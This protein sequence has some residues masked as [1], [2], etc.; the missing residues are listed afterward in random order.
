MIQYNGGNIPANSRFDQHKD[1]FKNTIKTFGEEDGKA[2]FA[3]VDQLQELAEKG[4]VFIPPYP[5]FYPSRNINHI[6]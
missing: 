1:F 4:N 2:K 5:S 3:K 6:F